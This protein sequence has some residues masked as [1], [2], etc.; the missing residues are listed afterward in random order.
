MERLYFT[1]GSISHFNVRG[2]YL[3]INFKSGDDQLTIVEKDE[4]KMNKLVDK[5]LFI[6]RSIDRNYIAYYDYDSDELRIE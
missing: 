1:K 3:Y 6:I 4:L 2:E 5:L